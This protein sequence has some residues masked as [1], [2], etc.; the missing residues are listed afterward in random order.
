MNARLLKL[1]AVLVP[2][3][4]LPAQSAEPAKAPPHQDWSFQ[5]PFGTYDRGALQ[6]GF[7]IYH[8]VCSACHG[9][10]RLH[11]Y[12]LMA[13]G[14]PGFGKD[15]VH[16]L[17]AT[18]KVPAGPD[19]MGETTDQNG[20]P[21]TRVARLSDRLPEPFANDKAAA[22][23]NGGV[24][25]PDLS[26]IVK[27]RKG[28]A[29]YIYALLTGYQGKPPRG[30]HVADGSFYNPYFPGGAIHMAPALSP[31]MVVYSDGT[32]AT[33][34]QEAKDVTTFLAWSSRPQLEARHRIG[35]Q[36]MAFL[37]VLSGLLFLS[38]RKLWKDVK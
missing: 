25:P 13:P 33:V 24:V 32:K 12:D 14:G 2:L 15:A 17:M 21:L 23:A 4:S 20:V 3:M 7:Q 9:V 35:L 22:A 27:G 5:G 16:N 36:V 30:V 18:M 31:D 10:S 29:D 37:V 19:A 28:G 26:L 11:F 8:E 6:R 1:C 38:W 34:P